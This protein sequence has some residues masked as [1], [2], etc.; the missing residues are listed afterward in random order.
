VAHVKHLSKAQSAIFP[1]W[2][3]SRKVMRQVQ[4]LLPNIY[5][6]RLL[7]YFER[8]GCIRCNGKRVVYC[9]NGLCRSCTTLLITRLRR[10]DGMMAREYRDAMQAPSDKFVNKV[11]TARALLADMVKVKNLK[12]TKG[13]ANKPPAKPIECRP[14]LRIRQN[15]STMNMIA[16]MLL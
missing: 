13:A 6:K 7:A 3:L 12:G 11:V 8:F 14:V 1:P 4:R 15:Q 5:H 2:F 10:C 16:K 9:S